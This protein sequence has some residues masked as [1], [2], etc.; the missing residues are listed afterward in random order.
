M[1]RVEGP[2]R[3]ILLVRPR[4]GL[5]DVINQVLRSA[6]WAERLE[7][8]LIVDAAWAAF[9]DNLGH[10]FRVRDT[11]S[12]LRLTFDPAEVAGMSVSPAFLNGD[13]M[14]AYKDIPVSFGGLPRARVMIDARTGTIL[15]SRMVPDVRAQVIV[16][17]PIGGGDRGIELLRRLVLQPE[18]QHHVLQR[19]RAMPEPYVAIHIRHTDMRT[20][21]SDAVR[22]IS[23]IH[24]STPLFV[25]SDNADVFDELRATFP[26][27]NI[28]GNTLRNG[29]GRP[30]HM[31]TS[32]LDP[33]ARNTHAIGDLLL[34][35]LGR[36]LLVP[37]QSIHGARVSSG[38]SRLAQALHREPETVLQL[39]GASSLAEVRSGAALERV[40]VQVRH[41]G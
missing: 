32:A 20:D 28:I 18:L 9:G 22:R 6:E 2:R 23:A 31:R 8:L 35:A 27:R 24:R 38:F 25:A 7:R 34:L 33:R 29:N 39:L 30:L 4:A 41:H 19:L 16:D 21:M 12:A 40:A 5:N 11:P 17:H 13:V 26:R 1:P 15:S 36:E 3:N 10:Y 37:E 14:A